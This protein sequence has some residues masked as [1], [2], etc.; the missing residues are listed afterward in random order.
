MSFLWWFAGILAISGA[1]LCLGALRWRIARLLCENRRRIRAG[2]NLAV[3]AVL[4][5]PFG[6]S[7]AA[8]GRTTAATSGL[9]V[10][11]AEDNPVN[12]KLAQRF[13]EKMGHQIVVVNNGAEA[14]R[15]HADGG[16][17]LIL[18]DLQMPELDGFT[19]TGAIRSAERAAGCHTPIVAITAHATRSDRDFCLAAG[20][21]DFLTKP[22]DLKAL[23][24]LI[25]RIA[26][27]ATGA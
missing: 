20:M 9:R 27:S 8:R 15:A 12:Q 14:V 17:D 5:A 2:R 18:M 6:T 11:L 3:D 26:H 21:D 4:P 25:D 1:T 13:V 16:F 10:L 19:A 7:V 23:A 24:N 22:I